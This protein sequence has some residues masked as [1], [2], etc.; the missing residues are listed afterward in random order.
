MS[1]CQ[2]FRQCVSTFT[3]SQ[4]Y[5]TLLMINLWTWSMKHL[6][7]YLP[8]GHCNA[9]FRVKGKTRGSFQRKITNTIFSTHK[10]T[11]LAFQ[12]TIDITATT[13]LTRTLAVA[14]G[15]RQCVCWVD[16]S[17]T[18]AAWCLLVLLV[19][20]L[21]WHLAELSSEVGRALTLLPGAALATIHTRQMTHHWGE[22][23]SGSQVRMMLKTCT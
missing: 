20:V 12:C 14:V 21:N 17:L 2:W 5:L 18:V 4:E 19:S 1:S 3:S 23:R 13:A 7:Y 11:C 10:A 6:F 22:K 8:C 16:L 15:Q 9:G